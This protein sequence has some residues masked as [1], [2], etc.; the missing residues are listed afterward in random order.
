MYIA[1][2]QIPKKKMDTQK[3]MEASSLTRIDAGNIITVLKTKF[4]LEWVIIIVIFCR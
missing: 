2:F 3:C 1:V 4:Q